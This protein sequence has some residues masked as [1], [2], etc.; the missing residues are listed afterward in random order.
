M[1]A[2][3]K[4]TMSHDNIR[5]EQD[6]NTAKLVMNAFYKV[7]DKDGATAMEITRYL[8]DKF[9]DVWR[10]TTLT[11]KAEE[12]LKRSAILGFLDRQGDRYVANLARE[13]GC[14][15]RRRRKSCPRRRR[16]KRACQR[17]RRRRRP[18]CCCGM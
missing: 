8:Q 7:A 13:L 12:T 11:W 1:K 10:T 3:Y 17:R 16:R 15:R 6:Q 4:Y 9:G 18:S 14:R 2:K 5:R